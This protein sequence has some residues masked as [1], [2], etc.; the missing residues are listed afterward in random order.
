M[1]NI[2]YL[3]DENIPSVLMK[4]SFVYSFISPCLFHADLLFF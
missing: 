2:P 4:Q 1:K 3:V